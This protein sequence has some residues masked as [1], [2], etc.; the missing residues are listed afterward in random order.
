MG[1]DGQR[2]SALRAE[3]LHCELPTHERDLTGICAT[4]KLGIGQRS[5]L[6]QTEAGNVLWDCQGFIDD[7]TVEQVRAFGA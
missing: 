2:V 5:L 3:G 6:V 7:E 4:P 1:S